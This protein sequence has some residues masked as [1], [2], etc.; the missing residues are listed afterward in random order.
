MAKEFPNLVQW[1]S[2]VRLLC[3]L[4]MVVLCE[5]VAYIYI[6][7]LYWFCL[8]EVQLQICCGCL[9]SSLLA[10]AMPVWQDFMQG[11]CLACVRASLGHVSGGLSNC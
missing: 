10:A 2:L 3:E 6:C 5:H 8:L 9:V 1:F 4:G 7:L 11:K